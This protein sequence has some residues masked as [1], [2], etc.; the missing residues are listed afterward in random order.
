MNARVQD[1]V[2]SNANRGARAALW[3]A[4][5]A[6]AAL[7]TSAQGLAAGKAAPSLYWTNYGVS[8]TGGTIGR[9]TLNGAADQAEPDQGRE[10]PCRCRRSRRLHLLVER[11][12]TPTAP[13]P[14][15]AGRSSTVRMSI[16]ASSP[17]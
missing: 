2:L 16:R 14:R 15:S 11:E 8:G 17:G 10:R 4:L 9:A 6:V 5:L 3:C 7:A 1:R 12:S 13:A